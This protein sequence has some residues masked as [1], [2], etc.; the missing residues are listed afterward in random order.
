MA[1]AESLYPPEVIWPYLGILFNGV[2]VSKDELLNLGGLDLPDRAEFSLSVLAM[3]ASRGIN[4]VSRRHQQIA[5]KLWQF[6]FPGERQDDVP[7]EGITNGVHVS[8]WVSRAMDRFY[9]KY[10]GKDYLERVDQHSLWEQVV[11]QESAE[12]DLDLDLDLWSARQQSKQALIGHLEELIPASLWS[13]CPSS[14][15]REALFLGFARRMTA[16]KRA[17]LLIADLERLAWILTSTDRP[18]Y[19]FV[20]GKA[21]PA[22][23]VGQGIL[24]KIIQAAKD[25]RLEG[26]L[27]FLENYDFE[28]AKLLVAGVDLWLNTPRPPMEASGTSGM[29]AVYNGVLNLS[30][31]DGWWYEAGNNEVGWVLGPKEPDLDNLSSDKETA[32]YLY[33]LLEEEVVPLYYLRKGGI[34]TQWL[35][36]VRTAIAELGPRFNTRRMLKEYQAKLYR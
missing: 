25:P 5:K 1:G 28:I 8:T 4:A 31:S 22:D 11:Q 10:L 12:G 19:L 13:V 7:I 34:P 14:V 17:N 35:A 9:R 30:V 15:P 29:K 32:D 27:I 3:R 24:E 2:N 20:S 33:R 6:V 36:K 26:H 16:Y 23:Q 21:H 18:V